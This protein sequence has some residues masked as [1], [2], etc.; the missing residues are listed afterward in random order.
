MNTEN[1]LVFRQSTAKRVLAI[2]FSVASIVLGASCVVLIYDILI[3]IVGLGL[4]LFGF[5]TLYSVFTKSNVVLIANSQG[6]IPVYLVGKRMTLVPWSNIKQFGKATKHIPNV[7]SGGKVSPQFVAVYFN[8]PQE[9]GGIGAAFIQA[10][11][12]QFRDLIS[13]KGTADLYIPNSFS[14]PLDTVVQRL[15]EFRAK[16]VPHS[17]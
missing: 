16:I 17:T 11:T 13:D 12:Q 14:E 8:Q 9:L 3:R 7:W 4:L 1:T 15:E 10:D 6:I 5:Y 2:I